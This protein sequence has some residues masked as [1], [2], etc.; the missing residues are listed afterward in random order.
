MSALLDVQGARVSFGAFRAVD[1]VSVHV[2][3]QS[4]VGLIGP[5]G[6]GKTTLFNAVTGLLRMDSG[7]V[8]F[9]GTDISKLSP[10]RR[11]RLGI[12]R[13][14][15]NLG[16]MMGESVHTN[17]LAAQFLSADYAGW[18]VVI[19]PWKW[20][21]CEGDLHD[22]TLALLEHFQLTP[23]LRTQVADLSFASAR[24]V[25]LCGVLARKPQL[26]LLDEPTTGLS[27][28]E[29]ERLRV[30]L[31]RA[32]KE[33]V[34]ILVISHDVSFVMTA[35]DRVYVLSEGRILMEGAPDEVRQDPAVISAYLGTRA[36]QR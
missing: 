16:L 35:T 36:G 7:T 28:A 32:R 29:C 10:V 24:F 34:T 20:R 1:D 33:G 25:E 22:R 30:A 4:I 14:F 15:Q 8:L 17:V 12:G 2:D 21:R 11:A 3:D 23:L 26:V 18:D 9:G 13:S 27:E 31:L 6:A 5:N 19:R